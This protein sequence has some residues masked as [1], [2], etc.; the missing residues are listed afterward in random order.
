MKGCLSYWTDNYYKKTL[1]IKRN[2]QTSIYQSF[3]YNEN[4]I[5]LNLSNFI[6]TTTN[7]IIVAM[8]KVY[9][10]KQIDNY[11]LCTFEITTTSASNIYLD[12]FNNLNIDTIEDWFGQDSNIITFSPY[13]GEQIHRDHEI[14]LCYHVVHNNNLVPHTLKD[15][16]PRYNLFKDIRGNIIVYNNLILIINQYQSYH[17]CNIEIYH[18]SNRLQ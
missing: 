5:N 17:I 9:I 13:T 4:E 12:S 8:G 3:A 2:N 6:V 10:L 1:Y 11:L 18:S 16:D 7:E 14:D 15:T